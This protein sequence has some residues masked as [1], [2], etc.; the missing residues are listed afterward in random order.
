MAKGRDLWDR[1]IVS[2][3]D[4]RQDA[5]LPD[6][7]REKKLDGRNGAADGATPFSE[8]VRELPRAT[9]TKA[10]YWNPHADEWVETDQHNAVIDPNRAAD[11]AELSD[12]DEFAW[13]D[14]DGEQLEA[15]TEDPLWHIP[16]SSYRVINPVDAYQPLIEAIQEQD[17]GADVFGEV[18]A[19]A[20]GGE[21]HMDLIFDGVEAQLRS[22]QDAVKMGLTTGYDFYGGTALYATAY[23][24]QNSCV[25]SI[26]NLTSRKI[27]KH[28]GSKNDLKQ[29]WMDHIEALFE[30]RDDLIRMIREASSPEATV[31][32]REL[33]FSVEEFYELIGLPNASGT[34]VASKAARE[35]EVQA[36]SITEVTMWNLHEGA[37]YALTYH[38]GGKEGAGST[39]DRHTRTANDLLFN[40]FESLERAKE[41]YEAQLME[42]DEWHEDATASIDA[43]QESLR[44]KKEQF[45][46]REAEL[47]ARL[48]TADG[49]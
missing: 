49:D 47:R 20:D 19:Y 31:N 17:L 16:T 43:V 14:D 37:T 41:E 11:A 28:T 13:G 32:F 35:A 7:Y 9:T 18:R 2:G 42:D 46:S 3:V 40:P 22:H 21:V 6:G 30:V 29:W 15:D 25:N 12:D 1:F 38:Y 44:E 23:A 34:P 36:N 5:Q 10:A 39:L 27:K 48:S 24:Q 26:R 45:E 33:P 4:P 8:V